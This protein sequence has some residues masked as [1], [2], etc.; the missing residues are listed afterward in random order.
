MARWSVLRAT[1]AHFRIKAVKRIAPCVIQDPWQSLVD[2]LSAKFVTPARIRIK[3]DPF[4]VRFASRAS[5]VSRMQTQLRARLF[6]RRCQRASSLPPLA[7]RCSSLVLEDSITA[8][9][10]FQAVRPVKWA[11]MQAGRTAPCVNSVRQAVLVESEALQIAPIVPWESTPMRLDRR[12]V[13]SVIR[14]L[15]RESLPVRLV[16]SV[17]QDCSQG[18]R[19]DSSVCRVHSKFLPLLSFLWKRS[20]PWGLCGSGDN[21]R[22][23]TVRWSVSCAIPGFICSNRRNDWLPRV[24]R[25]NRSSCFGRSK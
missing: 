3:P 15:T 24:W 25:W 21:T 8:N 2:R 9:L 5:S 19:E 18:T 20:E 17:R 7:S 22:R 16:W 12:R 23:G 6:A 11:S 14:A 4:S 1:L 13:P 10:D